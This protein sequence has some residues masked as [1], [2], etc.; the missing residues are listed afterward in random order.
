MLAVARG[1]QTK[2][3]LT[4]AVQAVL[5]LPSVHREHVHVAGVGPRHDE[6]IIMGENDGPGVHGPV[7]M[8]ATLAP[9]S[10]SHTMMTLSREL[11]ATR[12][13]SPEMA[14]LTTPRLW[15]VS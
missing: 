15:S 4:L 14:T 7:S 11:L 5:Q 6:L 10:V 3:E 1:G 13:P 12:L 2:G 9:V 8:V